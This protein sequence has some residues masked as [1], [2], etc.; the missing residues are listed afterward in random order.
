MKFEIIALGVSSALPTISKHQTAHVLNVREQF[1]LLDAGE[2]VQTSLKKWDINP[3]KINHIFISHLHGDHIFGIF[4][5]IS[6]MGMLGRTRALDI[7]APAPIKEILTN[8]FRF[9]EKG[10]TYKI[11]IHEVNTKESTIIYENNSISVRTIPLKHSVPTVGYLFTEREP[12]LN[13]NP[14]FIEY[15]NLSIAERVKVKRGGDIEREDGTIINHKEVTFKPYTPR[16][17]AYCLDTAPCEKMRE[18]IKGVNTLMIESTF[19]EVDKVLAKKRMHTTAK[20]AA[21]IARDANAQQL[22]LTHF[23][24]RYKLDKNTPNPFETE[25]KE[26]F[27]NSV[28]ACEG[29]HYPILT[30]K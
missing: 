3:L 30:N 27:P 17:F 2:G 9:F 19:L 4:G 8:H 12:E 7:F 25:A 18:V 22:I 23:S 14:F 24:T 1:Y 6:S 20:Q 16:S 10:I 21:E 13:L 5:L 15:Y 29:E 26:V 11:D 28:A